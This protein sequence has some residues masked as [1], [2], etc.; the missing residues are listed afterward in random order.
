MSDIQVTDPGLCTN[1][2]QLAGDHF[3]VTGKVNLQKPSAKRRIVNL[4]NVKATD[5]QELKRDI[6]S[7]CLSNI[8]T[9]SSTAADILQVYNSGLTDLMDEHAPLI[10]KNIYVK[11]KFTIVYIVYKR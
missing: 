6:S 2:G 8:L 3:A 5:V 7:S 10:Q 9:H 4:R 1:H 11:T